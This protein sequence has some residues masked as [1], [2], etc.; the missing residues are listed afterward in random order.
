METAI[1][2]IKISTLNKKDTFGYIYFWLYKNEKGYISTV[3]P[4]FLLLSRKDEEFKYIL[5]NSKLNTVDGVGLIWASWFLS[6][7][8]K[9]D[10]FF[11]KILTI[12]K[13]FFSLL[14]FLIYKN[15]FYKVIQDRIPG[16]ELIYDIV[17]MGKELNKMIFLLGGNDDN[18]LDIVEEKLGGNKIIAGKDIGFTKGQSIYDENINNN[19]INKINKSG[20]EIIFVAFGA[21]KQEKWIYNNI[22]RLNNIKLAIGVGGTFDF[23]AQ[24]KKRAPLIF[25]KLGLEWLFRLIIEPKRWKRIFNAVIKFPIQILKEKI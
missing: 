25:Q 16:S 6:T 22:D 23:I 9:T 24:Y 20:A 7:T 12:L 11:K 8:P 15:P 13:W 1:F 19:L 10:N 17:Q 21:P 18:E 14:L 2:D 4:E 5:Q 3:N